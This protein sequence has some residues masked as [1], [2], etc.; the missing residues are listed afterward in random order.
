MSEAP[1]QA[2]E[3]ADG[4]GEVTVD[5]L[6]AA[7]DRWRIYKAGGLWWAMRSGEN[8]VPGGPRSLIRSLLSAATVIGLGEQ[9]EL[10]EHLRGLSAA[11]LEAVWHQ[12]AG[13]D[14]R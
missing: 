10:Q 7:F 9:L 13:G 2:A 4:F 11:E 12:H 1:P 8:Q 3:E 6:R 5:M 14:A